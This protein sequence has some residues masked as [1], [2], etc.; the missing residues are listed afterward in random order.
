VEAH[1]V[2]RR[3]PAFGLEGWAAVEGA[4]HPIDALARGG[5]HVE[6]SDPDHGKLESLRWWNVMTWT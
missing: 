5:R 3:D 4:E 1:P 2:E 6:R